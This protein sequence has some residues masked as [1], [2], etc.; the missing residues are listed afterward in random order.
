[1]VLG[2]GN[3]WPDG[4]LMSVGLTPDSMP[5]LE[6]SE[7]ENGVEWATDISG[8][9]GLKL[10]TIEG[11]RFCDVTGVRIFKKDALDGRL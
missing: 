6:D 5:L 3:V 8:K 10:E 11:I 4:T 2:S 7:D 1:M 9:H